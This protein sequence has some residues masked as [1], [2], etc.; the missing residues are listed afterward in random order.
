[1]HR[2]GCQPSFCKRACGEP[3]FVLG[4]WRTSRYR[5]HR[6]IESYKS[7]TTRRGR[8]GRTVVCRLISITKLIRLLTN[9]PSTIALCGV[10]DLEQSARSPGSTSSNFSGRSPSYPR[11]SQVTL[12]GTPRYPS[13][14]AAANP[15]SVPLK[16]G[17]TNR[18]KVTM[19]SGSIV[20]SSSS[21]VVGSVG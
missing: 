7:N 4:V 14:T 20:T 6:S 19:T 12:F 11:T 15:R 21:T 5:H 10:L 18:S 9:R 1:M 17:K 2:S 3:P 13:L 8:D 16:Y